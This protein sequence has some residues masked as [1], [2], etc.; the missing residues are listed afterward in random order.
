MKSSVERNSGPHVES[1]VIELAKALIVI[2]TIVYRWVISLYSY[3]GKDN[4]K[5]NIMRIHVN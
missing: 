5:S 4:K 1:S 3:S 2:L